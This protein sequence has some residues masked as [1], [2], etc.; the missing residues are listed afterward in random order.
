MGS[1]INIYELFSTMIKHNVILIYHGLFDQEMIKS[2]LV[3]TEKKLE[4][5][6]IEEGLKKKLFN[7]MIEGLQN[8]AKHQMVREDENHPFLMIGKEEHSFHVVTG[9]YIPNNKMD[10]VREKIDKINSLNKEELKE[11]YK[12]ARLKSV[13]S[14]V[15]G[16]G[17]GFIDMARKSG[18]KLDYRFFEIDKEYSLFILNSQIS[19]N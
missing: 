19:N 16:A 7:V 1:T 13:I 3:M 8:V 15:G 12:Q 14:D 17:L 4:Q 6:K 11:F 2:V 5:E 10:I 18:N 9:N